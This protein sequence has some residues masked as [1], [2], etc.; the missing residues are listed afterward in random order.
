MERENHALLRIHHVIEVRH[1]DDSG[2]VST[3]V[4]LGERSRH[5]GGYANA[6][7]HTL[8]NIAVLARK[9][10]NNQTRQ[11]LLWSV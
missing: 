7:S 6:W 1:L 8:L 11:N 3:T 9:G 5:E 10:R 2:N 4:G